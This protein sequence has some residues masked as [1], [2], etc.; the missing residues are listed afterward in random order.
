M[1]FLKWLVFVAVCVGV[2]LWFVIPVTGD[3]ATLLAVFLGFAPG[4]AVA[5]G[6]F[7]W[8]AI[9]I[10]IGVSTATKK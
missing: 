1:S 6:F 10:Y 7:I 5:C 3:I 2:F 4:P 8:L 9:V